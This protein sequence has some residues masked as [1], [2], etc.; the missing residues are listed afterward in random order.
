MRPGR[1]DTTL[2]LMSKASHYCGHPL[3]LLLALGGSWEPSVQDPCPQNMESLYPVK[4]ILRTVL[5]DRIENSGWFGENSP[6]GREE[7]SMFLDMQPLF[8][9]IY[10][11]N[12]ILYISKTVLSVHVFSPLYWLMSLMISKLKMREVVNL[13]LVLC[14]IIQETRFWLIL[15][16]QQQVSQLLEG[17]T[18]CC[19][20]FH[21]ISQLK[22]GTDLLALKGLLI[23]PPW[24]KGLQG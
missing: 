14:T 1:N 4:S 19:L 12:F 17:N 15:G 11:I 3:S 8:H 6:Y 23:N 16:V 9:P 5:Y 18:L 22:K 24:P 7:K 21:H 20:T 2:S 10:P 13:V